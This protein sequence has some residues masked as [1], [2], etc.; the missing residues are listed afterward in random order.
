MYT[1][2]EG[3]GAWLNDRRLRVSGRSDLSKMVFGTGLPFGGREGLPETIKEF[4]AILP[5]TAGLRRNGTASLDLAY[6]AAGRFDGVWERAPNPW[7]IAAGLILVREA[8]GLVG[9]IG[10]GAALTNPLN[11]G[12]VLVGNPEAFKHLSRFVNA[13]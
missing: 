7:D 11:S 9:T 5:R 10:D 3:E 6:V 12:D 4:A 2:E 8:G 1:A 13:V